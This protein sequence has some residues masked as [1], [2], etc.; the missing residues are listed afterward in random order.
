MF[1]LFAGVELKGQYDTAV[2]YFKKAYEIEEEPVNC[3]VIDVSIKSRVL[4]GIGVAHHMGRIYGEYI[5]HSTH[6]CV[7]RLL[8][9]K[10]TRQ[11][12]FSRHIPRKSMAL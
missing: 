2:E 9:W 10:D 8:D 4:L 7:E 6:P 11:N 12:E 1:C 5:Y 3:A